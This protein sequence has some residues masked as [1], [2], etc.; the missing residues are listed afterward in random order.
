[1]RNFCF[2]SLT[3][4]VHVISSEVEKVRQLCTLFFL[5]FIS[6]FHLHAQD[7]E[8][9]IIIQDGKFYYTTIDPEFQMATLHTGG[10]NEPLKSGKKLAM[11][12]GRNYNEPVIPFS[13]DIRGNSLYA[14]NFLNHP[15]NDRNEALK[16]FPLS[17]L[18]P[19]GEH[20]TAGDMLMI[21]VDHNTFVMNDPYMNAISKSK[22]LDNFFYDGIAV[23]DS[24][25]YFAVANK[26]ELC[27][28]SFNGKEWKQGKTQ[29]FPLNGYFSL[30]ERSGE[31]YLFLNSGELKKLGMDSVSPTGKSIN[32]SL[33]TGIIIVNKDD[34][35]VKFLKNSQLDSS[36][37]L[38]ELIRK[39]ANEIF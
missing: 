21:S 25:Y 17:S 27:L 20:V 8:R 3:D 10:I 12:A 7:I 23:N 19:W 37:P 34:H 32:S 39:K 24:L 14:V 6:S 38:D 29:A 33:S 22:T 9:K 11:P 1:M 16:R 28:W 30:V 4:C 2:L 5:I 31:I 13:W 15:M 36:V 18:L 26:G 35:S